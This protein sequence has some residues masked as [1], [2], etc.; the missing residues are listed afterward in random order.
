MKTKTTEKPPK[1]AK[2]TKPRKSAPKKKAS[3]AA[4]PV[5]HSTTDM[6]RALETIA[7]N[8]ERG[9]QI[10]VMLMPQMA[11][12][13]RMALKSPAK[14]HERFRSADEAY[15]AFTR[16]AHPATETPFGWLY[17]PAPGKETQK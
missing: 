10:A 2:T 7:N 4:A 11:T 8:L 13:A 3:A 9:D 12:L 15:R 5:S 16:E 6:S 1:S 17:A 14:N